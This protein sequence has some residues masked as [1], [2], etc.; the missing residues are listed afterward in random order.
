MKQLLLTTAMTVAAATIPMGAAVTAQTT[1]EA[2]P[3]GAQAFTPDNA[4]LNTAILFSVGAREAQQALRNAF[5]WPT[6]QEGQVQGAYFRF[7]PDGYARF[8][9]SPRLDLDVFEVICRP[10]TYSC[11]ARKGPMSLVL[12]SDGRVQ[13]SLEQVQ[14]TDTF[15]INDGFSEL[16]IPPRV[17]GVLDGQMETLLSGGGSL[18]VRRNGDV[19]DDISLQ[20]F[21]SVVAYLRWVAARQ[22]Y[23]ALPRDWPVPNGRAPLQ[24]AQD[25]P[26]VWP[27]TADRVQPVPVTQQAAAAPAANDTELAAMKA[28]LALLRDLLLRQQ[29]AGTAPMAPA[30]APAAQVTAPLVAPT[31]PMAQ[32]Q[33]V[34]AAAQAMTAAG[35]QT[36]LN[37]LEALRRDIGA[38]RDPMMEPQPTTNY[39]AKAPAANPK[40]YAQDHNMAET[41]YAA[42][43][44]PNPMDTA[45]SPVQHLHYL[46]TA[47]G[48][49]ARTAL[50]IL[51]MSEEGGAGATPLVTLTQPSPSEGVLAQLSNTVPMAT[52]TAETMMADADAPEP[53]P[54]MTK[55]EEEFQLLGTYFRSLSE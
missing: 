7:D 16:Q 11:I 32:P 24:T 3:A 4:I 42:A 44:S 45:P 41:A 2:R 47:M 33:A 50:L 34:P 20:S 49:D 39:I 54:A 28:E 8:S 5:G 14:A 51:Q 13:M 6:Y 36:I 23:N 10:R 19:I 37:Q 48:F 22:D 12:S 1:T 27:D 30:A 40:P 35:E 38:G 9:P 55:E 29:S 31:M 21:S 26:S 17:K 25:V 46:T 52:P 18:V 43:P 53:L 15:A